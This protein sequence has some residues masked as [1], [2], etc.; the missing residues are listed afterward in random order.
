MSLLA[1]FPA[2]DAALPVLQ[3]YG[4]SALSLARPV[5]GLGA[6]AGMMVLFRPL[7][8][9][10]LRAGLLSLLPRKSHEERSLRR[11]MKAALR[12]YRIARD[13]ESSHPS[14]ASEL[15]SIAARG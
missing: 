7:L 5:F 15:R 1:I 4:G 11:N 3:T 9:G 13:L 8:V 6:L 12:I 10:I 2:V 14:L